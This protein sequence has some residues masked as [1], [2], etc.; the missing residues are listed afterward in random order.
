[1]LARITG[2]PGRCPRWPPRPP[3]TVAAHH[4]APPPGAGHN[5]RVAACVFCA[6]VEGAPAHRVWDDDEVLAFLDARP[7]FRGHTLVVPRSHV[8][9]LTDLPASLLPGFFAAVQ[10][11]AGAVER[12]V[13]AAGTFVAINNRVSQSVPHLHCH[14]VPRTKGDGLRGFFWPRQ[15]YGT[16]AEMAGVAAEIRAAA[17]PSSAAQG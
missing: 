5:R 13:G 2:A 4:V 1:M 15:S 8:E 17:G 11:L 9:T 12:A 3:P 16:E 14:I 6:I 7:V 10:H